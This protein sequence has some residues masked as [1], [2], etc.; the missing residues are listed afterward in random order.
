MYDVCRHRHLS[1]CVVEHM[2]AENTDVQSRRP[3]TSPSSELKRT[4]TRCETKKLIDVGSNSL[5]PR[6]KPS[7]LNNLVSVT[8]TGRRNKTGI[9]NN[10]T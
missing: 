5:A 10:A 8:S 1:R 9:D 3:D 7:T 6:H 4:V 2:G